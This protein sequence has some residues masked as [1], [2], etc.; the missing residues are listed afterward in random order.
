MIIAA[1]PCT[2]LPGIPSTAPR[3][4]PSMTAENAKYPAIIIISHT[5]AVITEAIREMSVFLP[6]FECLSDIA[7]YK[8]YAHTAITA[9]IINVAGA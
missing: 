7:L 4:A 8:Y 1:V 9:L 5:N 2:I 3:P 6:V